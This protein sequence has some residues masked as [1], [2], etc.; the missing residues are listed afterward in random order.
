MGGRLYTAETSNCPTLF[1]KYALTDVMKFIEN[2][3]EVWCRDALQSE[4]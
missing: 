4:Y 2:P 1:H 3:L